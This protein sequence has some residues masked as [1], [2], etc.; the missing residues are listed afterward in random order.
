MSDRTDDPKKGRGN[1]FSR[2]DFLKTSAT[3]AAIAGAGPT[4]FSRNAWAE[5]EPIGTYPVK[6][7]TV[8][9]GFNVPQTGAYADEGADELRAYKLAVKHLNNGGGML[10][11]L[12]PNELTGQGVLGKKVDFVTGDTQ[13]DPDAARTSARRMI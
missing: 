7:K 10:E 4:V 13:T 2:R 9:F 3:T 5:R 11:T 1:G 6:G 12:S 8:T